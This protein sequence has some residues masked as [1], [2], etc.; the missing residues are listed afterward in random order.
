MAG[1]IKYA[2]SAM[3]TTAN[4]EASLCRTTMADIQAHTDPGFDATNG[5]PIALFWG[6]QKPEKISLMT[7]WTGQN[8]P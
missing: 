4:D 7:G 8:P 3:K 6:Q 5:R 1:H 2:F